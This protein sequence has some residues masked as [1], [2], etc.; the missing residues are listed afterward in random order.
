MND[1]PCQTL[2][3]KQAGAEDTLISWYNKCDGDER[4]GLETKIVVVLNVFNDFN[5]IFCSFM[6][7]SWT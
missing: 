5:Y 7:V 4:E 1:Q 6:G 2:D 3:T